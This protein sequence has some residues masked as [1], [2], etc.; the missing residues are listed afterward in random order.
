MDTKVTHPHQLASEA[1]FVYSM[2]IAHLLNNPTSK[3]RATEAF[4]YALRC[5]KNFCNSVDPQ[6]E[7]NSIYQWLNISL[8]LREE[9]EKQDKLVNHPLHPYTLNCRETIGFVKLAFV[10]SFYYLLRFE[11]YQEAGKEAEFYHDCVK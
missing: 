2:A 10:L 8:K 11:K 4:G 1:N 6:Y 3:N 9:A 5:S 7:T